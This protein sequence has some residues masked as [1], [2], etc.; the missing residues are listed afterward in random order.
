MSIKKFT[1]ALSTLAFFL[2]GPT[3]FAQT[4][5]LPPVQTVPVQQSSPPN[6]QV[7]PAAATYTSDQ[8]FS[9]A[10]VI[11]VYPG[12]AEPNGITAPQVPASEVPS[13][14]VPWTQDLVH[15]VETHHDFGSVPTGSQ[16]EHVFEFVNSSD[17]PLNLISV[18]ASCGC[19]KPTILTSLVQPGET[20]RVMAKFDTMKFRGEKAATVTVGINKLTSFSEYG[21]VQLSVKGKIRKDVVLTPGSISFH[22]VPAASASQQTVKM[23]YAGNPLWKIL[24][25]ES[26]NDN[27]KAEAREL[28]R[29]GGRIT[30]ELVVKLSGSQ[31][32]GTFADE[33]YVITNDAR[34]NKMP[35]SVAGR[36]KPNLEAA[37]IKLGVVKQG[38]RVKKR[39]VIRGERPF[40][41][42]EVRVGNKFISFAPV[43][44]E[45]KLHVL[46][47]SLDTST[48]GEIN[49][50]ITVVTSDPDNPE[51]TV[52]FS[53]QIVAGN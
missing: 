37:P 28:K 31:A 30:Y 11:P 47:Y 18:K 40:E 4:Y 8:S 25:V 50:T 44:G 12:S 20:A 22:N 16:Q 2:G 52:A 32:T 45:K 38:T 21:E 6:G 23:K 15:D 13:L 34:V 41:I 48:V 33:L 39:F 3:V 29:A 24:R 49:D 10:E 19:T 27:I 14:Q 26:T 46:T 9:A 17:A 53:A 7:F 35:I 36:V 5:A 42:P 43:T 51:K 1:A